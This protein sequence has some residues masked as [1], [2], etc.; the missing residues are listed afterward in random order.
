MGPTCSPGRGGTKY[1]DPSYGVLPFPS[2]G[3]VVFSQDDTQ[4][5][6]P[7]RILSAKLEDEVPYDWIKHIPGFGT[8]HDY[9]PELWQRLPAEIESHG[10]PVSYEAEEFAQDSSAAGDGEVGVEYPLQKELPAFPGEG[11]RR[12]Y[13]T[14]YLPNLT[15]H[16]VPP[17]PDEE[18]GAILGHPIWLKDKAVIA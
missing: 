5:V 10:L 14:K 3:H 12:A 9:V 2:K 18:A 15:P 8:P 16:G 17:N 11:P 6:L 7:G 1:P 13:F 4:H